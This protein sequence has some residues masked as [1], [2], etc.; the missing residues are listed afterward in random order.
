VYEG[1][2]EGFNYKVWK[3]DNGWYYYSVDGIAHAS[4]NNDFTTNE[5]EAINRVKDIIDIEND[6]NEREVE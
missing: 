4:F 2:Y 6:E 5:R 1:Y 3:N